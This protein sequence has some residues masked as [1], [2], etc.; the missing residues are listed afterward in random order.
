MSNSRASL[1]GGAAAA[2]SAAADD[3]EQVSTEA[4]T[5]AEHN[6]PPQTPQST[7]VPRPGR[8]DEMT[9]QEVDAA[10]SL[11]YPLGNTSR[12]PF[13]ALTFRN[14]RLFFIGQLISVAG[15]WMQ[16]VAQNWLVWDVTHQGRWL[17]I[18]SG[19]SAIP[20]VAFAM[21]GGKVADR[22]SRRA[23]L[24]WTQSVAMVL[25]FMLALLATNRPI[26]LQAWHIALFAGLL[27][28]VNAFNMPA[29]QAFVTDMVDE[30]SAMSNA[31]ALNSFR[32]NIARFAGPI[33]AGLVLTR[34]GAPAC[35]LLNGLSYIAVVISLMMMRLPPY[36]PTVRKI[37]M[38]EG[39]V[40][41][42]RSRAVLRVTT[43]IGAS[44]MFA[45]AV[46]TLFP[47]ISAYFKRGE[48]GYSGI[49]AVQG[50]GAAAGSAMLAA[51]ADKLDRR[52]MVYGGAITF[53]ILLLGVAFSPSF[54]FALVFL[55]LAGFAMIVF[56]MSAQIRIQ[57]EVP[58]AL[59]GRVLAVYSLVFQGLM[60]VGGVEMGFLAQHLRSDRLF[61]L[62]NAGAQIAIALNA[63][64][65]LVIA[66]AL[67]CWSVADHRRTR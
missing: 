8:T 30:R 48:G 21:W 3:S 54:P 29:Q 27:G 19:A 58:D 59:R 60:P 23:V 20:Y 37:N 12:G 51:F 13:Y 33:L 38:L 40:Y 66:V 17:G 18:V 56:G 36:T 5:K 43:L 14:F 64:C 47:M 10:A 55:G 9:Q 39:V 35:F 16:T 62:P 44:S 52:M 42:W 50:I 45:W 63:S 46:S 49:M 28:I 61:G 53:C 11:A 2:T 6:E 24:V 32:F 34:Y 41:I 7:F 4:Q 25:A 22:Y 1:N 65:C 15:T 31:I 67:Y 26:H 57:E